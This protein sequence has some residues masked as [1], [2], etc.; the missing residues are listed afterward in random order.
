METG[1]RHYWYGQVVKA[2]TGRLLTWV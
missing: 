2:G 1:K